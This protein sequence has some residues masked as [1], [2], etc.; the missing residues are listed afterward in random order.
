MWSR[1]WA[2]VMKASD[3]SEVHL[4][5]RFVFIEAQRQVISSG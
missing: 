1:P 4:T 5:D 2:S 3:R